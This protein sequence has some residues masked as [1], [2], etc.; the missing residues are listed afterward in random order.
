MKAKRNLFRIINRGFMMLWKPKSRNMNWNA[1]N[2][3]SKRN[4]QSHAMNL[5]LGMK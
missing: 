2:I 4:Q 5:D 1:E 3:L